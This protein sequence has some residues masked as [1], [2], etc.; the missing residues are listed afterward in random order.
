MKSYNVCKVPKKTQ[1]LEKFPDRN[2]PIGFN[3]LMTLCINSTSSLRQYRVTNINQTH[4]IIALKSTPC[5]SGSFQN[6]IRG[7][8]FTVFL[9]QSRDWNHRIVTALIVLTFNVEVVR[10]IFFQFYHR[11]LTHTKKLIKLIYLVSN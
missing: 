10:L 1:S 5:A 11:K 8:F 4:L 7:N 2:L 6:F 3:V 9:Q